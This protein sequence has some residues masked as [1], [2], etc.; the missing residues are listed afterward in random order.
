MICVNLD[1]YCNNKHSR[2]TVGTPDH[3]SE[4]RIRKTAINI[5]QYTSYYK[6]VNCFVFTKTAL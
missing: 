5:H 2:Y 6:V 3:H 1:Q 4:V